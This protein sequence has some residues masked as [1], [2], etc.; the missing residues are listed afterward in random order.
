MS[1]RI[2][3]DLK[4]DLLYYCKKNKINKS[5]FIRNAISDALY[6]Q[7]EEEKEEKEKKEKEKKEIF[8]IENLKQMIA[9]ENE[10]I[11]KNEIILGLVQSL[12]EIRKNNRDMLIKIVESL[13]KRSL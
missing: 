13:E 3:P 6:G 4:K 5:A 9:E 8:S 12:G 2:Q 11:E 1:I 7:N 10:E